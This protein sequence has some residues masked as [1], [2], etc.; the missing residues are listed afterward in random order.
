MLRHPPNPP[1]FPP[2]ALFRWGV[3]G[4]RPRGGGPPRRP[5]QRFRPPPGPFPPPPPLAPP[6]PP[7]HR[8][9]AP[10]RARRPGGWNGRCRAAGVPRSLRPDHANLL[11][12]AERA[13][14]AAPGP[15]GDAPAGPAGPPPGRLE[16]PRRPPFPG[17]LPPPRRHPPPRGGPPPPPPPPPRPPPSWRPPPPPPPARRPRP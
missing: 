17:T 14:G 4:G 12:C 6:P 8:H 2:P 5:P 11:A 1:L 16:C 9:A 10:R 13:R 15:H 7:P 3:E